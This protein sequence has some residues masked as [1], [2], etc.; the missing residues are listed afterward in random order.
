MCG[1][2]PPRSGPQRGSMRP[3]G[4]RS[5]CGAQK[6]TLVP[7]RYPGQPGAAAVPISSSHAASLVIFAW[8]DIAR[9][10]R[11]SSCGR[12]RTTKG[13]TGMTI[14]KTIC[15]D[16]LSCLHHDQNA[17]AV[18]PSARA[19]WRVSAAMQ[20]PSERSKELLRSQR[21]IRARLGPPGASRGRD[22]RIQRLGPG[23]WSGH[24]GGPGGTLV[25]GG[26][27][28]RRGSQ[29]WLASPPAVG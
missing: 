11:C 20:R 15:L 18:A 6:R 2:S 29:G 22:A 16:A 5:R 24:S 26:P 8:K 10:A 21:P 27:H 28:H 17:L 7:C 4:E 3:C 13:T 25:K 12:E 1:Y 14:D 9:R 19:S 23:R